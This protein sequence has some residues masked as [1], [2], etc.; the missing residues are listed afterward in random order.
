MTQRELDFLGHYRQALEI[1]R[2]SQP[3]GNRVD[4]T[5]LPSVPVQK[6]IRKALPETRTAQEAYNETKKGLFRRA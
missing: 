2:A 1:L 6:D 5:I 3:D 4:F